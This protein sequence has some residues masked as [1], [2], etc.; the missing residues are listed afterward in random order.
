MQPG[1]RP[2]RR[3]ALAEPGGHPWRLPRWRPACRRRH[4]RGPDHQELA[5]ALAAGAA[6]SRRGGYRPTRRFATCASS[7]RHRR[8][9][10][11]VPGAAWSPTP[12]RTHRRARA[13]EGDG[14]PDRGHHPSRTGSGSARGGRNARMWSGR[15]GLPHQDS[16]ICSLPHGQRDAA[17]GRSGGAQRMTGAL[18]SLSL[19]IDKVP[20]GQLCPDR[21]N[22]QRISKAELE[23]LARSLRQLG[24]IRPLSR[25]RV[26]AE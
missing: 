1:A 16:A 14:T 13:P 23:E 21:A 8:R 24:R 10:R 9:L 6:T 7:P 2:T 20:C 12:V 3:S 19:D 11:A 15:E 25:R 22:P 18:S 5:R 17:L 26:A 4:H